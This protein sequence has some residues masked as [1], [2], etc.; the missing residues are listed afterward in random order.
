LTNRK[1]STSKLNVTAG[2]QAST[3][4]SCLSVRCEG[5]RSIRLGLRELANEIKGMLPLG[6]VKTA[7]AI[8]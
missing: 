8:L 1:Q 4:R 2:I 3:S 5:Y 7:T 6:G